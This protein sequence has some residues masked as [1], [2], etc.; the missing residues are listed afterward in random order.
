MG[1]MSHGEEGQNKKERNLLSRGVQRN[2]YRRLQMLIFR[3]TFPFLL[4]LSLVF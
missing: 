2:E 1:E 3:L 4:L